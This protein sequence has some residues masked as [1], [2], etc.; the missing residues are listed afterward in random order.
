MDDRT[1]SRPSE[2]PGQGFR[3]HVLH[4]EYARTLDGIGQQFRSRV[5]TEVEQAAMLKAARARLDL[6]LALLKVETDYPFWHAWVGV[7][8]CLLYARRVNS[9]PPRVVR[10]PDVDGLRAAIQASEADRAARKG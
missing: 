7:I 9:S 8:P 5:V 4:A 10:A 2:A 6:G 3:E 1:D